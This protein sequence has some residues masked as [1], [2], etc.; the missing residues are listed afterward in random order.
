MALLATS[1]VA[2]DWSTDFNMGS[3]LAGG[4]NEAG[5][6]LSFECMDE[7]DA[8]DPVGIPYLTLSPMVGVVVNKKS[9]PADGISFW[10][11][12]DKSFLVPMS[13]DPGGT[14][15]SYDYSTQSVQEVRWL[16]EALRVGDTVT[17]FAGTPEDLRLIRFGLDGSSE[18]LELIEGCIAARD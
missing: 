9:V 5:G 8:G 16:V 11:G 17:A 15:L 6:Y 10:V 13:V 7:G 12:D 14:S 3:L 4:G 1:A 2:Q 18:A